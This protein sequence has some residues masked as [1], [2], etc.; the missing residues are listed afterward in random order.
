V[1]GIHLVPLVGH[2]ASISAGEYIFY[3][4]CR[5]ESEVIPDK[6]RATLEAAW[7]KPVAL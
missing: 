2:A 1:V 4:D 7:L 3:S 6:T 5:S